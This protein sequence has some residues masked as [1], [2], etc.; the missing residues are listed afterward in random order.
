MAGSAPG[1]GLLSRAQTGAREGNWSA[2][3]GGDVVFTGADGIG[4]FGNA[5]G[6]GTSRPRSG[7]TWATGRSPTNPNPRAAGCSCSGR[8]GS[9]ESKA[10]D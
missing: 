7:K 8:P 2:L 9:R 10:V 4:I 6:W 3:G 1:W 5:G